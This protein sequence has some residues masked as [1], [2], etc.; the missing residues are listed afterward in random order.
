MP[1]SHARPATPP[2]RPLPALPDTAPHR[3]DVRGIWGT[4]RA[5]TSM[6]PPPPALPPRPRPTPL[7]PAPPPGSARPGPDVWG[8][9][10]M[11]TLSLRDAL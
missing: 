7:R 4:G 10:K 5:C 9:I 1:H 11:K 8:G 6:P 2:L 3:R